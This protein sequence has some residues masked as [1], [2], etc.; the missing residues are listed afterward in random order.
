MN[1]ET[2]NKIEKIFDANQEV[3]NVFGRKFRLEFY[4]ND[5]YQSVS[6]YEYGDEEEVDVQLGLDEAKKFLD[7]MF[8]MWGI[9]EQKTWRT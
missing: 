7:D 6:I 8:S 9:Y 2:M 1:K 5:A 3:F 4:P